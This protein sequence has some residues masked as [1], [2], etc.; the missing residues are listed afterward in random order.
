MPVRKRAVHPPALEAVR[1]IMKSNSYQYTLGGSS[2]TH[3]ELSGKGSATACS[4][5]VW[6]LNTAALAA[7]YPLATRVDCREVVV[8]SLR[9]A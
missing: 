9:A 6:R 5:I 2:G 3:S 8:S 4:V 7:K 1:I